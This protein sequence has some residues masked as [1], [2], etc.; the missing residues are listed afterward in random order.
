[1]QPLWWPP[2]RALSFQFS[3]CSQDP[4]LQH[5]HMTFWCLAGQGLDLTFRAHRKLF[6]HI[7]ST[8]IAD[9][10]IFSCSRKCRDSSRNATLPRQ[11]ARQRPCFVSV[12]RSGEPTQRERFILNDSSRRVTCLA[13]CKEFHAL[14][15][16]VQEFT[17]ASHAPLWQPETSRLQKTVRSRRHKPGS[18]ASTSSWSP[19]IHRKW[20]SALQG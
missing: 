3:H 16:P 1:M 7:F 12:S 9:G 11:I 18:R 10:P 14:G 8:A 19:A 15:W 2:T 6:T 4:R 17:G 20:I 5:R 13:V